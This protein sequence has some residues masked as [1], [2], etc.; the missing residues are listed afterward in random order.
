MGKARSRGDQIGPNPTDQASKGTKR[1]I[2]TESGGRLLA[3]IVAPAS[4]HDTK[5]LDQTI[6][7]IAGEHPEPTPENL[8]HLC[9]D[10]ACNNP[11]GDAPVGKHGYV[12]HIRRIGEEASNAGERKRQAAPLG[13]R[14]DT[15]LAIQVP[16]YP[17]PLR[18]EGGELLDIGAIRLRFAL[19][20]QIS[21][22]IV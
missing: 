5:S 12:G 11:T 19:V 17:R 22:F 18:E 10:K 21:L 15:S 16:R 20:P 1:S 4:T 13:G 7:A 9:L 3:A 2:L 8:Q 6:E 14:K